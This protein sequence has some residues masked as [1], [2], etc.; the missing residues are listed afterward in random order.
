MFDSHWTTAGFLA[1]TLAGTTLFVIEPA[2]AQK[3]HGIM[4]YGEAGQAAGGAGCKIV[5]SPCTALVGDPGTR[6]GTEA[7]LP[8]EGTETTTTAAAGASLAREERSPVQRPLTALGF[9]AGPADG[10]F[11]PRTRAAIAAWQ[12]AN[13]LDESGRLSRAPGSCPCRRRGGIATA[14]SAGGGDRAGRTG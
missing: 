8:A 12:E 3:S 14:G 4:A 10:T 5:D 13:G 6:R 7:V 9:S 2:S 1:E 11:G